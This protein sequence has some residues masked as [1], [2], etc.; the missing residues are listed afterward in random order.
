MLHVASV[1]TPCCRLLRV[2]GSCCAKFHTGQKFSYVKTNATTPNFAGPTML[3]VVTSVYTELEIEKTLGFV[4][5][6]NNKKAKKDDFSVSDPSGSV[7]KI[8]ALPIQWQIQR[9]AP[10][11]YFKT[12]LRPKGKK[13]IF[14]GDRPPPTPPYLK[15]SIRHCN[16]SRTYDFLG[17]VVRRPIS[18]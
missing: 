9:T 6:P 5:A 1:C 2:V 18:A 8:R 13:K 3:G 16:K 11:P 4:T 15:V 12:K 7:E 14:W 17:P 10:S